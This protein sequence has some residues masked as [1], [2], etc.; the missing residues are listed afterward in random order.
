VAEEPPG[1]AGTEERVRDQL[2]LGAIACLLLALA[3]G[4]LPD[5]LL[6]SAYYRP[7]GWVLFGL[8]AFSCFYL[9]FPH[10]WVYSLW[11]AGIYG[12]SGLGL[13][14]I[15]GRGGTLFPSY[16]IAAVIGVLF[17]GAALALIYTLLLRVRIAR[18]VLGSRNPLGLWLL[19]VAG[20]FL[21][22]NLS[23]ASWAVWAYFGTAAGL[24]SYAALEAALVFMAVFICWAPETAVWGHRGAEPAAAGQAAPIAAGTEGAPALLKLLTGKKDAVIRTCPACGAATSTVRLRC[25][26][27]GALAA[28]GW[29]AAHESYVMAC[30]SCGAPTLSAGDR[31]RKCSA[32]QTGL[33]CPGCKKQSPVRDWKAEPDAAGK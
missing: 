20:F 6:P 2:A 8:M 14:L 3:V 28:F 27:C 19:V 13:L 22:S 25:P 23:A 24:A 9:A 5:S 11:L 30:P 4:M 26:A 16:P 18:S 33:A 31:C 12:G 7:A 21:V 10:M 17:E 29:C 1:E 32:P 15:T